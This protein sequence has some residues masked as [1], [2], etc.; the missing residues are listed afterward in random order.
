[1]KEF[2]EFQTHKSRNEK[3]ATSIPGF[4]PRVRRATMPFQ[5]VKTKQDILTSPSST[6]GVEN[7]DAA[8]N[9]TQDFFVLFP[10]KKKKK[11]K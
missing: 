3:L 11:K 6:G 9:I 4:N 2:H 7:A 1:M 8:L 10:K 5:E